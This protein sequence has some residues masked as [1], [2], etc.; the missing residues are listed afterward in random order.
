MLCLDYICIVIIL[1]TAPP[2]QILVFSVLLLGF[3]VVSV[4]AT[5]L[6]SRRAT[7]CKFVFEACFVITVVRCRVIQDFFV[8]RF[9][10]FLYPNSA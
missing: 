6:S 8:R 9:E 3:G 10:E 2:R 1:F 4:E 7:G 5:K